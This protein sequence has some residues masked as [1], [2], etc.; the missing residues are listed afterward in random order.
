MIKPRYQVQVIDLTT[1]YRLIERVNQI[2]IKMFVIITELNKV[3]VTRFRLLS[4]SWLDAFYF[5]YVVPMVLL[6]LK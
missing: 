6:D 2:I 4:F 3:E 5:P 1:F